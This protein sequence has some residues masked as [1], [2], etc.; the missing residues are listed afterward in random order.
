MTAITA[1]TESH[2]RKVGGVKLYPVDEVAKML[3]VNRRSVLQLIHSRALP[4]KRIGKGFYIS[5]TKLNEY[6]ETPD[7]DEEA[8]ECIAK[9]GLP[10]EDNGV[11]VVL[12]NE[13]GEL[14]VYPAAVTAMIDAEPIS[15]GLQAEEGYRYYVD[16]GTGHV[17]RVAQEE[18]EEASSDDE[19]EEEEDDEEDGE[20]EE[21][22]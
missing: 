1:A 14:E 10:F 4:A 20:E 8:P 2:V 21:E 6:A 13:E 9:R 19:E 15:L 5:E 7:S 18:E 16:E 12:A 22:A 17:M 11:Y 3:G